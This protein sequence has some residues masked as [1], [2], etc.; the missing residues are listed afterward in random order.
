MSRPRINPEA[1]GM[2]RHS[3]GE[4]SEDGGKSSF[5]CPL[6]PVCSKHGVSRAGPASELFGYTS[7]GILAGFTWNKGYRCSCEDDT[8]ADAAGLFLCASA[9]QCSLCSYVESDRKASVRLSS[10][11]FCKPFSRCSVEASQV[12]LQAQCA[13]SSA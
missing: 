2:N 1:L 11:F 8:K 9:W 5:F 10:R 12:R 4:R 7:V 13:L 6:S 3:G